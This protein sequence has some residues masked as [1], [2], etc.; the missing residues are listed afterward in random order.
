MYLATGCVCAH[1]YKF[2]KASLLLNLLH[3]IA[4]ELTFENVHQLDVCRIPKVSNGQ[5]LRSQ[6][7]AKCTVYKKYGT[8]IFEQE[9]ILRCKLDTKSATL[10]HWRSDV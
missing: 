8:D 3:K 5:F 7:A 10:N 2:S 1:R 4:A 6:L 9:K